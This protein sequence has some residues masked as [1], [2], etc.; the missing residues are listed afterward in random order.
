MFVLLSTIAIGLGIQAVDTATNATVATRI[1]ASIIGLTALVIGGFIASWSALVSNLWRGILYG[2]LVW[3]LW[4][5]LVM[6]LAAFGFGSLLGSLGGL[7]DQIQAPNL[8][9]QQVIDAI[10]TASLQSFLVLVLTAASAMV[11]GVLGAMAVPSR[12]AIDRDLD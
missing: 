7:L 3:A 11:G 10:Q 4:L 12:Y 8:S 9:T 6:V 5:A 2:F 1:V